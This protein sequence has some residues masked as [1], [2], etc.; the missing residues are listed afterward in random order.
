[1]TG[2]AE[3]VPSAADDRVLLDRRSL[4]GGQAIAWM[5]TQTT[6][7]AW[8]A[9]LQQSP[10]GHFQQ[11]ALWSTVK[12]DEGWQVVRVVIRQEDRILGGFQILV[13]SQ[14]GLRAGLLNKGPVYHTEDPELLDWLLD[15]VQCVMKRHRIETLMAQAPDDGAAVTALEDARGYAPNGLAVMHTATMCVRLG[16][17]LPP[18]ETRFRKTIQQEAR[19]A[20]RRGVVIREGGVGDIP[21]F[22]RMM[23]VTSRRQKSSPNPAT[24]A[25]ARRLY[26]AFHEKGLARL[27]LAD[28]D[29]RPTAGILAIRFGRRVTL[30]KKGWT[31]EFREKHPNT[32]LT[33]ELLQWAE[34]QG[35]ALCD[36]VAM[37]RRYARALLA[38][39]ASPA[40]GQA[41]RDFFLM[42]FGSEP[43]LLPLGRVWFRRR[44]ARWAYR[45]ALPLLRRKGRVET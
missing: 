34:G 2:V 18:I 42:G 22:F 6:D 23:C 8:D 38:G 4:K 33:V 44:L 24:E 29:G 26:T 3:T 43:R 27:T 35:A 17:N 36:F 12:A 40:S 16:P 21:D 39:T 28:C 14:H 9:F 41:R 30:W 11:S 32:L 1:M 15:L 20:V 37:N 25:A 5:S 7:D 10:L 19:Q 45:A 13:Q 31:E